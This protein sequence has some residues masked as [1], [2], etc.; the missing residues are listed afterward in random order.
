VAGGLVA[1]ANLYAI[2]AIDAG[3]AGGSG[4]EDFDFGAGKEAEVSHVVAHFVGE[5]DRLDD[6][7]DSNLYV[8]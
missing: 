8:T 2:N 5:I 1:E 6:P 7:V 3:I 4:A